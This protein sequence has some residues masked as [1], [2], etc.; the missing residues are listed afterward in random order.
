MILSIIVSEKM[1][2]PV[3]RRR[4]GRRRRTV[5]N[6]NLLEKFMV[7]KKSSRFS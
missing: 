2:L 7:G 4:R 1:G 5:H 6:T 3:C